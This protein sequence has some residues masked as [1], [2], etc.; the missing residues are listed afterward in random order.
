MFLFKDDSMAAIETTGM[1]ATFKAF[2]IAVGAA[3]VGV[4][5]MAI[6]RMPKTRMEMFYQGMVAI[7]ASILF[8][9]SVASFA[10]YYFPFK[11]EPAAIH[12]FVGALSWGI[13]GG[14]AHLRDKVESKPLDESI[15]D[16]RKG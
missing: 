13:F 5:I 6:M 10:A 11:I 2:G 16:V 1:F 15:N 4:G 3:A 9:D 8:G 7:A 12:G 14:L